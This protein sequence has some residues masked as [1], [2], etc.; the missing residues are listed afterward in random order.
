MG[1]ITLTLTRLCGD[2]TCRSICRTTRLNNGPANKEHKTTL[3][4]FDK[5]SS[6]LSETLWRV[7]TM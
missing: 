3:Q 4:N 5:M 2:C 7:G 6:G 1:K